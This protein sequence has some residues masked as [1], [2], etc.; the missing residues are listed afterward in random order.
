MYT[1]HLKLCPK[2][3]DKCWVLRESFTAVKARLHGNYPKT[4]NVLHNYKILRVY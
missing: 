1:K 4:I 3:F 2:L